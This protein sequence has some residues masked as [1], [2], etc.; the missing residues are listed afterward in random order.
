MKFLLVLTAALLLVLT[1]AYTEE[2]L[3]AKYKEMSQEC[4]ERENAS[5]QDVEVMLNKKSPETAE[6]KCMITCVLEANNIV[7]DDVMQ[8]NLS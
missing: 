8:M 7:S 3:A 6:G 5:D 1:A 4:K 2:E